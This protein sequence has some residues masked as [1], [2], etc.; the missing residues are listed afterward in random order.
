MRSRLTLLLRWTCAASVVAFVAG[1][2][3]RAAPPAPAALEETKPVAAPGVSVTFES[4]VRNIPIKSDARSDR[5]VA[6][7][8]PDNAPPTP[9]LPPGPF[10]ATLETDLTMRLRDEI[11][12][13]VA[14]LGTVKLTV[15]DQPALHAVFLDAAKTVSS[16]AIRLN[17]G[18][19]RVRVDFQS[20]ARGDA[21]FR[22]YWSASDFPPEPV[23]PAMLSHD[24]A[25]IPIR[26][27]A[28]LRTGRQLF[29]DLRCGACHADPSVSSF[30]KAAG[31]KPS[32]PTG[33]GLSMPELA[34]DAPDLAE[35]GARRNEAWLAHWINHPRSMRPDAN[36]PRIFVGKDDSID[37]R[38]R[39]VAAY[40]AALGKRSAS[41]DAVPNE[42]AVKAGGR[43]F[44][45]LRCAGCHTLPENQEIDV[46][47][48]R[49]PLKHV[50]SKFADSASLVAFLKQPERHYAWIRMPNFQFSDA[51]ASQLAAF[52]LTR[53]Q[54]SLEPTEGDPARGKQHLASSGCLNC[55][56]L[57]TDKSSLRSPALAAIKEGAWT[58]GCLAPT[59]EARR[60]APDFALE[61][62]HRDALLAFLATD[63]TALGRESL[64]E[65]SQRQ[66]KQLNCIACHTRDEVEDTFT[67]VEREVA[68]L[69]ADVPPPQPGESQ[70]ST[71]QSEPNLTW[72]GEKLKPEWSA[73][74]ING[75]LDYHLRPW[76]RARMPAFPS[77]AV[78]LAHGFPLQHGFSALTEPSIE[79]DPKLADAGRK[80]S[81][82][83]GGFACVTCH[84]VGPMKA[85]GV[86]E[87]PGINL[88]YT[89]ERLTRHY[90]DRWVYNP[91]RVLK[92]TKM[93]SF[94]DQDGKTP[95]A[96]TLEGDARK[97]YDAIY[98]YTREGRK[99][100]PP[101][102]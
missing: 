36:M 30:T 77:R 34:Q 46:E 1:S 83:E 92:D 72:L 60:N 91:L 54:K 99:I 74:L 45:F 10:K 73:K 63:R 40:L 64:A 7:F 48:G 70:W 12:F 31:A 33:S 9:F 55:H 27:G 56:A 35:I 78:L 71:D 102:N 61:D 57:G 11:T 3:V 47:H 14:A 24:G 41:N 43:L 62:D 69:V 38:A 17:K 85:V 90:F 39:D 26:E 89:D 6:L 19:N 95:I 59:P 25:T 51:E 50:K 15:N 32:A 21:M 87:A 96:D 53:E 49:V 22:L 44:A 84:D 79:R 100:R 93:P 23:P 28:R 20:P 68:D 16:S 98:H 80:L 81:G 65:F 76:L 52:L 8:V 94:A 97:Q 5:L 4:L 2:L 18:K 82:K 75:K 66:F 101:E 58:T 42:E 29:A 13:S 67:T 88:Q 37:P 86:F